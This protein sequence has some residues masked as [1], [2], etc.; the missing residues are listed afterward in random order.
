MPPIL[1]AFRNVMRIP[2]FRR[3]PVDLA[4]WQVVL[5]WEARRLPF[6]L[7]VGATGAVTSAVMLVTAVVCEKLIGESIG[8]PDP[9]VLIL[10]AIGAYAGAANVCYT[11]GW[12]AELLALKVWGERA[13]SFGE[14]AFGLGVAF[15][16]LLTLLPAAL[17]LLVASLRLALHAL[18]V[19][20]LGWPEH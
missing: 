12:V 3:D 18:G 8:M 5:W 16:V 1:D 7:V 6:N 17:T 10:F 19:P 11:G 2:L 15:S 14:I 20:A 4:P 13:R 9:P